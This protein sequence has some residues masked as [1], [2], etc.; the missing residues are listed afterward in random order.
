ML[1]MV[2]IKE[3]ENIMYDNF[4]ISADDPTENIK[5]YEM[6]FVQNIISGC[7]LHSFI[8]PRKDSLIS[9]VSIFSSLSS[10]NNKNNYHNFDETLDDKNELMAQSKE[11]ILFRFE[12]DSS[13]S[14]PPIIQL[15]A[16]R[17]NEDDKKLYDAVFN[18][19]SAELF[20]KFLNQRGKI[21]IFEGMKSIKYLFA[22]IDSEFLSKR[23][24]GVKMTKSDFQIFQ[25]A[26]RKF[27][28]SEDKINLFKKWVNIFKINNIAISPIIFS[29]YYNVMQKMWVND[30]NLVNFCRT[31]KKTKKNNNNDCD[32]NG[33]NDYENHYSNTNNYIY[34]YYTETNLTTENYAETNNIVI[35]AKNN[36]AE[37]FISFLD[38]KSKKYCERDF[39]GNLDDFLKIELLYNLISR[40]NN[41]EAA[42]LYFLMK[43]SDEDFVKY[44]LNNFKAVYYTILIFSK[45]NSSLYKN[46]NYKG[47][48]FKFLRTVIMEYS[49][50][51]ASIL[52]DV[53]N[54]PVNVVGKAFLAQTSSNVSLLKVYIMK[55]FMK[56]VNGIYKDNGFPLDEVQ[57][58]NKNAR[59]VFDVF[60][61][62][63]NIDRGEI[64]LSYESVC[65]I[66]GLNQY[67]NDDYNTIEN[68]LKF[69]L[70]MLFKSSLY[71]TNK[72]ISETCFLE[73]FIQILIS[74]VNSGENV[75]KMIKSLVKFGS[76]FYDE[77]FLLW[78]IYN[79]MSQYPDE[80][81]IQRYTG[82]YA[83]IS[84][85]KSGTAL[86]KALKSFKNFQITVDKTLQI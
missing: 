81:I 22:E 24:S 78:F 40:G 6:R 39:F 21:S 83:K 31:L 76:M 47:E 86:Y 25:N 16:N 30:D 70:I 41:G 56:Y 7:H 17:K 64:F 26:H 36:L 73:M 74:K 67:Y 49:K 71:Y 51:I 79:N 75:T 8:K 65:F 84:K 48:Y 10:K 34:N 19:M 69:Y 42:I 4:I 50:N 52:T 55:E 33:Y 13:S 35:K 45:Y 28:F 1:I 29:M 14:I 38:E 54:C 32:C 12:Y 53:P 85:L 9:N 57:A 66:T 63:L 80:F 43:D 23:P 46:M 27:I 61:K 44:V 11:G 2:F 58:L 3:S 72:G 18:N 82:E 62:I 68:F 37:D 59:G 15:A 5:L 77:D 20:Q 60:Q